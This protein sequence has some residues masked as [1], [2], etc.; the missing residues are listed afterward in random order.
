MFL[1]DSIEWRTGNC[2]AICL[3]IFQS[4]YCQLSREADAKQATNALNTVVK[5][6]TRSVEFTALHH[7]ETVQRV[8]NTIMDEVDEDSYACKDNLN[9]EEE[10][11]DIYDE[12]SVEDT[13]VD[14]YI[15]II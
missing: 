12:H 13:V 4:N 8:T 11:V 2:S 3:L 7:L 5:S 15:I 1:I 9:A 10:I 6:I 14:S